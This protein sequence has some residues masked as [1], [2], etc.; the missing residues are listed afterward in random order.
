MNHWV[1]TG[2]I[3]VSVNYRLVPEA[4]PLAQADDVA[5]AVAFVQRHAAEWGGDSSRLVLMGHSAGAH[6][7]ALLAAAPDIAKR[8]G[9]TPWLGTVAL[10]SAAYDVP[11]IMEQPHFPLYD[12]AFGS[13]RKLWLA[14]SPSARLKAA[15]SPMLLVCSSKRADSC[16]VAEDFAA[17]VKALKGVATVLPLDM[18]HA[19]INRH[20]GEDSIYTAAVDSFVASLGS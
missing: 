20:L 2:S 12:R 7:V 4:D 18:T 19:E 14:A 11:A 3:V 17:Q 8:G 13:D 1:P 16:P 9:A 5:Q 6:L 15:P 10:D